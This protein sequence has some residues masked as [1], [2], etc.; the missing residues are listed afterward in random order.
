M[1]HYFFLI[2]SQV[3]F[4]YNW[5]NI[6]HHFVYDVFDVADKF[7]VIYILLVNYIVSYS[8]F[9]LFNAVIVVMNMFNGC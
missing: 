7:N 1:L 8:V 5:S 9:V 6:F 3:S 4:F 2:Y